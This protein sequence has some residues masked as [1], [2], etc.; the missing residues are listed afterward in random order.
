MQQQNVKEFLTK[1]IFAWC[2]YAFVVLGIYPLVMWSKQYANVLVNDHIANYTLDSIFI[3]YSQA[4]E[5]W[6]IVLISLVM[7]FVSKKKLM[8][9]IC[10]GIL[11]WLITMLCKDLIFGNIPRPTKL[12]PLQSFR[13]ILKDVSVYKEYYSFPSGHSMLAF[14]VMSMFASFSKRKIWGILFFLIAFCAAFS[15]IYLLQHFYV[16]TYVGAIL[17][18]GITVLVIYLFTNRFSVSDDPLLPLKRKN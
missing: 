13:H 5:G 14:S 10:V 16:D 8:M 6:C 4:F 18:V 9:F 7:L 1:N 3:L 17:G 15:R 12:M 2:F 11:C